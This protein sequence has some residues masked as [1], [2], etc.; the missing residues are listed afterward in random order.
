M[1]QKCIEKFTLENLHKKLFALE[2]NIDVHDIYWWNIHIVTAKIS[3]AILVVVLP[4]VGQNNL[5]GPK[6]KALKN[7]SKT[8]YLH[9]VEITSTL[10]RKQ[11]KSHE[12]IGINTT[13]VN[14]L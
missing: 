12:I 1:L 5:A 13:I 7:H 11:M 6:S 14:K 9:S 10:N 3:S 4:P 8:I 2:K